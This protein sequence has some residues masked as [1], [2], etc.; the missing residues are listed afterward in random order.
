M[1]SRHRS[2]DGDSVAGGETA[3]CCPLLWLVVTVI[4][5]ANAAQMENGLS[6][7]M[8]NLQCVGLQNAFPRG[9]R[10]RGGGIAAQP[11]N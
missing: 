7:F 10:L 6:V 11:I 8:E 5:T 2:V 4:R 9:K 3:A 1:R